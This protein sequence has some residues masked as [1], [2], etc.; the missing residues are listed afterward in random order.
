MPFSF[1][2]APIVHLYGPS[3]GPDSLG[4]DQKKGDPLNNVA[5]DAAPTAVVDLVFG[6]A[7]VASGFLATGFNG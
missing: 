7:R 4:L 6:L 3:P 1:C 5:W 2:V